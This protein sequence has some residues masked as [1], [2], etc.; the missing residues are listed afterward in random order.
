MET[1]PLTTLLVVGVRYLDGQPADGDAVALDAYLAAAAYWDAGLPVVYE[2]P[3]LPDARRLGDPVGD[4]GLV[5]AAVADQVAA[6]LRAGR[7]VL[8]SGGNCS[9]SV[10][11]LAGMQRAQGPAARIGL[12]WLDA[13]G[14]FNT[15]NTTRSGMLGG[16]PLAVCAGLGQARWRELAGLL[17]PLPTDRIVLVDGRNLDPAEDQL[18]RATAVSVA[19]AAP[20]RPGADLAA[21]VADLAA[22]CDLIYLHV[23]SDLLDAALTPNHSTREPGGVTLAEA[24]AA[25]DLVL[26]TGKVAVL[27]VVAVFGA[28]EGHERGVA[29]GVELVQGGLAAWCR[30]GR[31][32]G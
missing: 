3:R 18:I 14:D 15:P 13:H 30:Y 10:G 29:A 32:A 25:M 24:L 12:V 6:G 7:A 16:M 2:E 11:V 9:H 22:R 19:A 4:L 31:P 17:S 28:G 27:A 21:A 1:S 23:D 5:C 8:V 20:G 26:A